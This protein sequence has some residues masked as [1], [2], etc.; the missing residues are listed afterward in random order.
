MW[1]EREADG[2]NR[3]GAPLLLKTPANPGGLS[4]EVLDGF[5]APFLTEILS[6]CGQRLVLETQTQ[7]RLFQAR[8][9]IGLPGLERK[10]R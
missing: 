7:A 10:A 8:L 3:R 5:R 4:M 6:G 9:N 1:L 2:R